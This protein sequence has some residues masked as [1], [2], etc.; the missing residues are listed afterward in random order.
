MKKIKIVNKIIGDGHPCF[1]IAEAGV[2]H[3][4]K[5]DLA[6]RLVDIAKLAGADAVKFQT[7]KTGNLVTRFAFCA[8]Y[9][10][11]NT[12]AK[13]Q[14]ELLKKLELSEDEFRELFDYC[15]TRR[16]IFLSTPSDFQSVRF[17][18][19]LGVPAFKIGSGDLN[20]IPLLKQA[21]QYR[22][23]IILS[24]GMSTLKEVRYA[25][26]EIYA[27]GNKK[28]ILLHCTSCYPTEFEDV[29]LSAMCALREEFNIPVG[30]SDHTSG[31]QVALA[32]VAKGARVIE[33]HFTLDKDLP[34]PDHR[35]SLE[36]GELKEM[37]MA[38][39]NIEKALGN[40]IKKLVKSE[41][42]IKKLVRKSIVAER[43]IPK[44]TVITKDM[45]AIKRPGTGI[46]PMYLKD[47]V[48]KV[49]KK[50]FKKDEFIR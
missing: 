48:G 46:S 40:G 5:I 2:N 39:R 26:K 13:S 38:I 34:G 8:S 16:I 29:N 1:I 43:D 4:G 35:A 3:N 33:K 44:G 32:A 9:Q 23:P 50:D 20:N 22:K 15:E 49:A 47:I 37:I 41:K 18:N 27:A 30:Y 17:L 31:I 24:T 6:K 28:L 14:F 36:P 25:V 10:K 7:Y 19:N 12:K 21:A 42:E 45:L 11:K